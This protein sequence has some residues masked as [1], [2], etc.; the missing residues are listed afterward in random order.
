VWRERF[1]LR[2]NDLIDK[3]TCGSQATPGEKRPFFSEKT[4]KFPYGE[5]IYVKIFLIFE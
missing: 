3:I 2:I 1:A 4:A 5:I